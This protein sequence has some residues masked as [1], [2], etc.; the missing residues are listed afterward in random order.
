MRKKIKYI[1]LFCL[2]F[3]LLAGCKG[4]DEEKDEQENSQPNYM[5]NQIKKS[6]EPCSEEESNKIRSGITE[7]SKAY[8]LY[9]S[10]VKQEDKETLDNALYNSIVS[11]KDRKKVKADRESFYK[12]K[13]VKIDNVSTTINTALP[14]TYNGKNMGYVDCTVVI[15]GERDDKTFKRTYSLELLVNY[16][17]DIVSIYEIGAI[18]WK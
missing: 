2:M 5:F 16:E 12:A 11:D 13:E 6:D 1:L 9:D 8:L 18:S 17:N 3:A 14:A 10:S 15:D 7:W 4:K